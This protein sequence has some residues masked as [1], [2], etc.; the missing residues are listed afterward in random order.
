M[1]SPTLFQAATRHDPELRGTV[2]LAERM[3]PRTL[4]E[5]L[6]QE[7]LTATGRLLRKAIE[8]DQVP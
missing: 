6:G 4:D 5:Y 2:P 7:H 8:I 1:D 3:R